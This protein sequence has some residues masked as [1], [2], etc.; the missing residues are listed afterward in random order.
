MGVACGPHTSSGRYGIGFWP[1]SEPGSGA[2]PQISVAQGNAARSQVG[3]MVSLPWV[4][5]V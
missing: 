1:G 3:M 5:A 4:D 2:T